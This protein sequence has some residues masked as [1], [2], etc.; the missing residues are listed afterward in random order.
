MAELTWTTAADEGRPPAPRPPVAGRGKGTYLERAPLVGTFR[1]GQVADRVAPS[2]PCV[3]RCLPSCVLRWRFRCG[4]KPPAS[5]SASRRA[6]SGTSVSPNN[7]RSRN[8]CH[9]RRPSRPLQRRRPSPRPHPKAQSP[10][11]RNG[12]ASSSGRTAMPPSTTP[13]PRTWRCIS[14][15]SVWRSTSP[16]ALPPPASAPCSSTPSSTRSPKG[17]PPPSPRIW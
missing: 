17:P 11:R 9:R 6:G 12:C 14:T 4:R 7:R 16:A 2:P 1:G 13:R 10:C 15:C 3:P 8:H 5:I